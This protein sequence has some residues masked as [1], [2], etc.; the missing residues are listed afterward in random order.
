MQQRKEALNSRQNIM[1]THYAANDKETHT[2]KKQIR[3]KLG[4]TKS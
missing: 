1:I 3:I 2:E 4:V